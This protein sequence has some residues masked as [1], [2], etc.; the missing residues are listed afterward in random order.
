MIELFIE[1]R[2]IDITDDIEINFN[3]ET[4]DTDKL[5]SIKNSFS[6]TVSVPGTPNNNITFGHL[7]RSDKYIP[8]PTAA[9]TNICN[10][11]D[12]HKKVNWLINKNGVLVN[13]GYCT[14]DNIVVKNERDVTY[15]L[16]LYGG[17]GEF[18]YSLSY[19]EDGSKKILTDMFWNWY[20][21][22][23]LIGHSSATTPGTEND[24]I[25][26]KC[27][28]DIVSEAYHHLSPYNTYSGTTDFER[29]V[30]FLP[31]YSGQ[32][33]DFDSKK[34]LVSTFNQ[35]YYQGVGVPD[36]MSTQTKN[37]LKK[38]FP[39]S[40]FDYSDDPDNPTE[41]VTLNSQLEQTGYRYGIASFSR[42]LDP[43][44]AGDLRIND[45]PVAIR[46]SKLMWTLSN[47]LNNGG[48]TV[49]WDE[50][51]LNSYHWLYSW[52][53]LGKL[54]K[55]SGDLTQVSFS[56]N[57]TYD[58]QLSTINVDIFTGEA[59]SI[60]DATSYDLSMDS[61]D[62]DKGR[63]TVSVNVK[64][65][66]MVKCANFEYWIDR[67]SGLISGSMHDYQ[68]TFRYVWTTPVL[69]H[70]I[71]SGDTLLKTVADI[72]YF[73]TSPEMYGFGYNQRSNVSVNDIKQVLNGMINAR[74]MG[75]GEYIDTFRYH[76]C[77]LENPTVTGDGWLNTITY[78]CSNQKL[79]TTIDLNS[80]ISDF[81]VEQSQG[82]M[83]TNLSNTTAITAGLYGYDDITFNGI[84][85]ESSGSHSP[86]GLPVSVE[87]PYGM[88][89]G[90]KHT[91]WPYNNF[92]ISPQQN[93]SSS[94]FNMNTDRE[95][96]VFS[97]T[98]TGF[99][100]IQLDKQ[101][102]FANSESPMKYLS[103]FCKM[104]N[105][106]IMC[107]N[108]TKTVHI[109]PMKKYYIDNVVDIN[110]RVDH[111]RDINI[112]NIVTNYNMINFGLETTE[113]YP[114]TVFDRNSREKFNT[115][116]FDTGIRYNAQETN[117]LNDIV[118]KNSTDWQQSSPL[119]KTHPQ[120]P[121]AW[122]LPTISW[123]LFDKDNLSVEDIK[124]K[125]FFT[126]GCP[127]TT[128]NL[129]AT[130]DF[131]PKVSM[132]DKNDKYVDIPGTMLFLNGFVKNYDYS[133][134]GEYDD[135]TLTPNSVNSSH[136]IKTDGTIGT[137]QYQ[138]IYIYNLENRPANAIYKLTASYSSGYGSYA[139]NYCDSS[140]TV[141]GREYAQS[142]AN[143][144]DVQLNIPPGTASIRCNFRKDDSAAKLKISVP[145]YSISP[146]VS[147]SNDMYEQYY[148]AGGR[149]YVYDFK[150]NDLFPGWGRYSNGQKG[151][152]SPWLLPMFSRDL[153]N[154]YSQDDSEWQSS[155]N[156]LA[157]WNIVGQEGLDST[158]NL[159]QTTFVS[160]PTRTY[161]V[162]DT[163]MDSVSANEYSIGQIPED[164]ISSRLWDTNWKDYMKDIYDRNTREVT[165]YVDL[166]GLGD[167]ND[168][169]RKLYS[170]EGHLFVIQKIE[171][172]RLADILHDKFTKVTLHKIKNKS[173][174]VE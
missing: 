42:E 94:W 111:S 160:D 55:T 27:S 107:D 141:I 64:P 129:V 60:T 14:L 171:N 32:Y 31:C 51:I 136:Y 109:M 39:D 161:L 97:S 133:P 85:T 46:L 17:I 68:G 120:Y 113:T 119:Y 45:L 112:K 165:M 90:T 13:R 38:S 110:D 121:R 152:A 66:L 41:Y 91:I 140:G 19:N 34:M 164:T 155:T 8:S 73:S 37:S 21:K 7:F 80:D 108:T 59:D 86:S 123:T 142:G 84:R 62:V 162:L 1:G 105:Y 10:D 147:L 16:T 36:Y 88:I 48:Y 126:V 144:V 124:S 9:Q 166:T 63:W 173:T 114:T 26:M 135:T 95:N 33:E 174:W 11:Y 50:D 79:S 70:K 89:D 128:Q 72:F 100:I 139:A 148:L 67:T 61:Q 170:Y 122:S 58:G 159:S 146:R 40:I 52:I 3:Y 137:T 106:R 30:V 29:D 149:C 131:L 99:N 118:F 93:Y 101:T 98:T 156:K 134:T 157:S 132:F 6:K 4:I 35:N 92:S 117:L 78:E 102:L 138:D 104:M 65:T 96:G 130:P 169:M 82:I 75:S 151:T 167:A 56:P 28:A 87:G 24:R 74:F 76:N 44:E 57:P 115:Y 127:S 5:S 20:P 71:Y 168:I 163:D 145:M 18:F 12:P 154:F 77:K 47:P 150:Y 2:K 116:R 153:Y 69:V 23:G 43:W 53:S 158:Y 125:E 22:T 15:K 49:E 81:R 172:F 83:W 103:G 25:L 143:Y 54:N